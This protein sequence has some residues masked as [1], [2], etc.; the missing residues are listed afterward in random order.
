[1]AITLL[2]AVLASCTQES[3]S[4]P[5]ET[6]PAHTTE[7]SIGPSGGR[8]SHPLGMSLEFPPDALERAAR[9]SISIETDLGEFPGSPEG[10]LIPG[11]FFQISPPALEVNLPI[12]MD[13]AVLSNSIASHD[14]LRL[15]IATEN[16]DE[17]IT[18]AGISFDLTSG[19]MHGKLS[20]LGAMAAV[21]ADNALSVVAQTPPSL[22]GGNF[23]LVGASAPSGSAALTQAATSVTF[24][25]ECGHSGDVPRCFESG[26]MALWASDEIRDRLSTEIVVLNPAATGTLD[27]TDFVDGVPTRA[28]GSLSVQGTLRV[29]LGR[30]ITS[31][32]VDDVFVTNGPGGGSSI[33]VNE[34][35]IT[36]HETSTGQHTVG[37]EIRTSGAGE[38][39]IL[40]GER[41]FEFD[42]DDGT[43]TT[44]ALFV[45]LRLQR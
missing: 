34:R 45:D 5:F 1:M 24:V 15:G 4:L 40:R 2:T 20:T 14:L 44:A 28:T 31:F 10:T 42:N 23:T 13:V 38:Q 32:E 12:A 35:S 33:T 27:F 43:K 29:Q 39:L 18:S 8:I 37:F 16:V 11:T 3:Q 25:I 6:D 9:I 19:I 30:V 7:R 36:L 41:S 21:V 22:G 17:P 26:T